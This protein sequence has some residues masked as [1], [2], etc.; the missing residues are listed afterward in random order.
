MP[1]LPETKGDTYNDMTRSS[2]SRVRVLTA[3]ETRD[4]LDN[5]YQYVPYRLTVIAVDSPYLN[6]ET[7][8]AFNTLSAT[9][10]NSRSPFFSPI[11]NKVVTA[12]SS[13][14][15]PVN[16]VDPDWDKTT[17]SASDL[18]SGA[19]FDTNSHTFTWQPTADQAG[20][21]TPT[22]TI[23]DSS[24]NSAEVT[25]NIK[26]ESQSQPSP[27]PSPTVS[28]TATIKATATPTTT[29]QPTMTP[30]GASDA[31]RSSSASSQ[32]ESASQT[33]TPGVSIAKR[34]AI[35]EA[36]TFTVPDVREG[37]TYTWDF[38]DGTSAEG[39]VVAHKYSQVNRYKVTLKV[40]DASGA[41]S[42]TEYVV[43][44]VPPVPELT[45]IDSE[46]KNI[47][48]TG[49]ALAGTEI[50]ATIRSDPYTI[51]SK[52]GD[53]GK[54]TKTIDFDKTG[55]P[56]GDHKILLIASKK[57]SDTLTL[58]SDAKEYDA[59]INLTV[60]NNIDAGLKTTEPKIYKWYWVSGA[61]VL[62]GLVL[63]VIGVH[64]IRARA[65]A[66]NLSKTIP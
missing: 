59:Y 13:L 45:Y 49:K 23:T 14:S 46:Q 39:A 66:R 19:S 57:I 18:P 65:R 64:K 53:D 30:T 55:L 24:N 3:D 17:Y 1:G 43:D 62:A 50:A 33:S 35:G 26:V 10:V 22:F 28:P 38:G 54:F 2:T 20:D 42:S 32:T 48:L 8:R 25:V 31:D 56:Y 47:L 58:Q 63:L 6:K 34:K 51:I 4:W 16:G 60:N 21:Y 7:E 37:S 29:V 41:E 12:G 5:T 36:I 52:V 44:I 9:P 61:G 40:K 27:T 15:F 11:T